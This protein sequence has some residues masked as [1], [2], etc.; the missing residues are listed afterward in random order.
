MDRVA[1]QAIELIATI[2]ASGMS[3]ILIEYRMLPSWYWFRGG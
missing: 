1:H 2:A 3:F